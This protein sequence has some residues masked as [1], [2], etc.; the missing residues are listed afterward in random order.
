MLDLNVALRLAPIAFAAA[1]GLAA[2][3][4]TSATYDP[5]D[6]MAWR[7]NPQAAMIAMQSLPRPPSPPYGFVELS[8]EEK[9]VP[10]LARTATIDCGGVSFLALRQAGESSVPYREQVGIWEYE[11]RR[12]GANRVNV[13]SSL[14]EKGEFPTGRE[15]RRQVDACEKSL[16]EHYEDAGVPLNTLDDHPMARAYERAAAE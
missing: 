5:M 7:T 10:A 13:L 15:L 8:D 3:N 4:S 1:C 2:C 16:L 9:A 14:R 12:A 11:A 6:D